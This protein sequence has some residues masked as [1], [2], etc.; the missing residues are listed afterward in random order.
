MIS[1][2]DVEYDNI[3]SD[4]EENECEMCLM[5]FKSEKHKHRCNTCNAKFCRDCIKKYMLTI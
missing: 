3:T 5:D 1:N 4:E 2:I